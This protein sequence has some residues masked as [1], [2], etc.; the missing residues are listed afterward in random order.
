MLRVLSCT[1][2]LTVSSSHVTYVFYSESTFQI[3]LSNFQRAVLWPFICTTH[4]TVCSYHL[5]Y[6]LQTESSFI[7]CLKFKKLLALSKRNILRLRNYNVSQTHNHLVLKRTLNHLA[8][9]VVST[10]LYGALDCMFLSSHVRVSEGIHIPNFHE[11]QRTACSKQAQY[12]KFK[13]L[14]RNLHPQPLSP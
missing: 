3:C 8:S 7:I 11:R 5:R 1:V 9:C 2:K 14:Q 10:Y 12:L 6:T 13:R 4:L